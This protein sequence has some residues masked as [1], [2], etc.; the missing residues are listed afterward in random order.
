MLRSLL[1]GL[2]LSTCTLANAQVQLIYK[3]PTGELWLSEIP[4]PTDYAGYMASVDLYSIAG[5]LL[6]YEGTEG[7]GILGVRPLDLVG[8]DWVWLHRSV[9]YT[10]PRVNDAPFYLGHVYA[11]G[12]PATDI[13]GRFG[14][15]SLRYPGWYDSYAMEIH[16]VPEPATISVTAV[17]VAGAALAVRRNF[18]QNKLAE[19]G[20]RK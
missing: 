8:D 1:L 10:L 17:A 6:D 19:N 16:V 20:L 15:G 4:V 5:N 11:P 13:S 3:P 2:C 12:T 14:A 7:Y 9:S 18:R